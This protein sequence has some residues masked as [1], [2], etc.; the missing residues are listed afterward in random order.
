M[1]IKKICDDCSVW[2]SSMKIIIRLCTL[3]AII[4][5]QTACTAQDANVDIEIQCD[6]FY[7]NPHQAGSLDV[8]MGEE[9]TINLCSNP[10]TGFQWI[11]EITISDSDIVEQISHEYIGPPEEGDPPPPGTSG[12]QLWKFKALEVGT[13]TL[14]FEYSRNWE[15]GEKGEWTL[16]LN[17]IVR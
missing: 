3:F 14:L 4:I 6:S 10:S 12:S 1:K 15:G 5:F 9:F 17:I 7:Q 13:S 8:R 11:E 16:N 2:S